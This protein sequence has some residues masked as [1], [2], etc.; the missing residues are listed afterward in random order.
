[1]LI[2]CYVELRYFYIKVYIV[3]LPF[4]DL[5][6]T[7]FPKQYLLQD[8]WTL[9]KYSLHIALA[10]WLSW[11]ECRLVHKKFA[12]WIPGQGHEWEA[13]D[14]CFS[15]TFLSFSPHPPPKKINKHA[16]R[17]GF[18]TIIFAHSK[19]LACACSC[20]HVST[21][22][23]LLFMRVVVSCSFAPCFYHSKVSWR[24]FYITT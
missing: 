21:H 2:H 11:L 1:M 7:S 10:G 4:P 16:L 14:R 13:T 8:F 6:C 17:W 22:P 19:R 24:L 15:L 20:A 18:K 5:W 3:I 12:G 23:P 9:Q